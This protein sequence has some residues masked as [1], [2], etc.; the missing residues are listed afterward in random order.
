M[1]FET[2]KKILIKKEFDRIKQKVHKTNAVE[3]LKAQ[4]GIQR[5]IEM[6]SPPKKQQPN[7]ILYVKSYKTDKKRPKTPTGFHYHEQ[8]A[9]KLY[10]FK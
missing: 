7:N 5:W 4:R 6:P 9:S 8:L 10:I 1:T 2:V 3:N